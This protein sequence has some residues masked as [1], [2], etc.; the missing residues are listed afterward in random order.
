MT[1]Q[2]KIEYATKK[3]NEGYTCS[4]AVLDTYADEIGA[5]REVLYRMMEGLGGG[6]GGL[7]EVCGSFSGAALMISYYSSD[8]KLQGGKSKVNTY[9]DVRWAADRFREMCGSIN[10][11]ELLRMEGGFSINCAKCVENAIQIIEEYKEENGIR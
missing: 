8:G 5:C 7:Q 1:V 11:S 10:C 4:Q 2:E 9:R 3:Y 6:I